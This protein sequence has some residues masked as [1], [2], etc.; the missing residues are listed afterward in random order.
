M[1]TEWK[2][3]PVHA[4]HVSNTLLSA[5]SEQAG[6]IIFDNE[7]LES[8][9]VVLNSEGDRDSVRI[10]LEDNH[11]VS[12]H[13]HPASAYIDAQC[14]YGHPSGDDLR[15]FVRLSLLGALNHA[16]FSLE[17]IYLVQVH[18]KFVR[19]MMKLTKNNQKLILDGIYNF[20]SVFHGKRAYTNVLKTKYTPQQF[21]TSCNSFQLKQLN[22]PEFTFDPMKFPPHLMLC[23]WFLSDNMLTTNN[24]ETKLWNSI[25]TKTIRVTFNN[26]EKPIVFTFL[27]L[28]ST[29]RNLFKVLYTI[30]ECMS[31]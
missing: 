14:V 26:R 25:N 10:N 15:E 2:I 7:N 8:S 1:L 17:G 20:F 12:F 3:L 27:F 31:T 13:T 30:K 29:E 9:R 23:T 18:P 4:E 11:M 21:V 28:N 22:L 5:S 19:Y 24:C 16:V 6:A